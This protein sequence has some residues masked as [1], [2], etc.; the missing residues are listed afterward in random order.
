MGYFGLLWAGLWRKPMRTTFTLLSLLVAFMLFGVLQDVNAAFNQLVEE[1]RLDVLLTVSPSGLPLPLAALSRIQ[2]VP[3]ITSTTYQS[4]FLGYFQTVR[5]N[6]PVFAVD[7]QNPRL[8]M[9]GDF[10]VPDAELADFRRMRTGALISER[11]AERF[12]WKVGDQIPVQALKLRRK[13]GG[14]VWTLDIVGIYHDA[15]ALGQGGLV[16]NFQYFDAER[17]QDN[18]TVQFYFERVADTSRATEIATAIDGLFVNSAYP[19]RTDTERGFTRAGL[20]QL[21]DLEFFVDAI[22]GATFVTLLLLVGSNMMQSFRERVPE[23]AV[24]KTIGFPDR[25][26]AMLVLCE[27]TLLC[28]GAA[29]IGLLLIQVLLAG[30]RSASGGAIPLV[31]LPWAIVLSGIAAAAVIALW[32]TLPAAW[33]AKRLSVVD[34]LAAQ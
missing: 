18:G 23:F 17:A 12:R 11:L 13:D 30:A 29:A 7:P 10:T 14:T 22:I 31:A 28:T 6:V 26:L 15:S 21:G 5:N 20:S 24:M 3:G 34:S 33:R 27:A 32:S 25:T 16:M 9:L 4:G 1:G 8:T 2:R 19:T